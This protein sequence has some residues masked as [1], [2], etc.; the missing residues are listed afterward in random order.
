MRLLR[1]EAGSLVLVLALI[2]L[3]PGMAFSEE[4][5]LGLQS[6]QS[7][8]EKRVLV[9][10]VRFPDATPRVP[11]EMVK[12]RADAL[13]T[14]VVEQSY[15]LASVK[16]DFHGYKMLPSPLGKYKV[17]QYNNQVDAGRV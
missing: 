5:D 8:G 17:S 13:N 7:I 15:G 11:L 12:R 10:V 6:T 14:Y 1:V 3:S 16:A 4:N 9:V 2:M